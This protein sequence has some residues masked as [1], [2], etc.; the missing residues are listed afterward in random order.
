MVQREVDG[1]AVDPGEHVRPGLETVEVPVD[2][3]PHVLREVARDL[4]VAG[5]AMDQ[6]E[7]TGAVALVERFEGGKVVRRA[8]IGRQR[9]HVCK[10]TSS[11]RRTPD[12]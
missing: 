4:V 10:N 11:Q 9:R 6:V 3:H 1:D 2:A 8:I 5:H 12:F 7:H